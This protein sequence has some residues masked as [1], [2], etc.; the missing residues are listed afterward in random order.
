MGNPQF[1]DLVD[2]VVEIEGVRCLQALRVQVEDA[3]K[4]VRPQHFLPHGEP[5]L[6][7]VDAPTHPLG[8]KRFGV[9]PQLLQNGLE[10]AQLVV[11]VVD[12]E[13]APPAQGLDV[14]AKDSHAGGVKCGNPDLSCGFSH[15]CFHAVAHLGGRLVGER[16][17]ED[18]PGPQPGRK[19]TLAD[20]S[21]LQELGDT[22]G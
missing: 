19:R 16:D 14:L 7:T 8:R 17:R 18:V 9:E 6:V 11:V 22:P 12:Y 10:H 3:R 2:Q 15:Q 13:V 1:D 20:G 4:R 21:A 5:V